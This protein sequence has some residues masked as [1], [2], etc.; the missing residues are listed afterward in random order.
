MDLGRDGLEHEHYSVASHDGEVVISVSVTTTLIKNVE[1]QLG[2]IKRKRSAQVVDNKKG[3]NTVQHSESAVDSNISCVEQLVQLATAFAQRSK[4]Y[5][6]TLHRGIY[7]VGSQ[8]AYVL[9]FARFLRIE[10]PRISIRCAL[11]TRRS[12]MPSAHFK[13]QSQNSLVLRTDNLLAGKR[14]S[15]SLGRLPAIVLSSAVGLWKLF[16]GSRTPRNRSESSRNRVHVPPDSPCITAA[17]AFPHPFLRRQQPSCA[18]LFRS[19]VLSES[20]RS[21]DVRLSPSGAW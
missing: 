10:S 6:S 5:H 11:C 8:C 15:L 14:S 13:S 3:S 9:C 1:P 21:L 16:L 17:A 19:E 2:L 12:R 4:A 18:E 20:G 7:T